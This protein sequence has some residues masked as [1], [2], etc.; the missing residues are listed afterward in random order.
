MKIKQF[1]IA[2]KDRFLD[3]LYPDD[4]KCIFCGKDVPAPYICDNC[5]K[6]DLFNDGNRCV[7][8][9]TPLKEGNMICDHCKR[10]KRTFKKLYCP[11][12]YDGK[13]RKA[14]LSLK[15]DGAKY[16]AKPFAKFIAERLAVEELDF[17]V[18]VPV[19]SHKSSIKLRG[20]NP[21][22]VIALELGKLTNKPVENALYKSIKTKKQKYLDYENRQ[23]NLENSMILLSNSAVKGKNVLIVDDIITTGATIEACAQMMPRAKNIY[24]CAVARRPDWKLKNQ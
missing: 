4:I 18:I 11:F 23:H 7:V 13:V 12:I 17:D 20:Y 2:V 8:C 15:S 1:L 16:L 3:A 5:L 22:E 9:D 19:P 10:N 14:I 21:A 24:A 6:D